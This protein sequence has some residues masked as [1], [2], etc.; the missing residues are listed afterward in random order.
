MLL[1]F[2][3]FVFIV[4][5]AGVFWGYVLAVAV[6][7]FFVLLVCYLFVSLVVGSG[8]VLDASGRDGLSL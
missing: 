8:F 1:M 6:T 2:S 7:F 4:F 5:L 3:L